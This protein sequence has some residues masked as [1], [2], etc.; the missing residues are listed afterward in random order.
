MQKRILSQFV[1]GSHGACLDCMLTWGSSH[2]WAGTFLHSSYLCHTDNEDCDSLHALTGLA[3][4][5]GP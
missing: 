3:F 5:A 4:L 1:Y 2:R